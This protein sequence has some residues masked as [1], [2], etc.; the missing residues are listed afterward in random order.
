MKK[1]LVANRGEIAIRVFRACAEL[2]IATVGIYAA[3]DE[4]SVHRFKADEAYLIGEGKKPIEAYLDIEGIIQVAKEAGAD[5]IH[6]GYGF[7]SENLQ[8]AKRCQEEGLT[9]IGPKLEHLD[10]FGDKIKAKE[11]AVKAG[12]QSIPGSDGPVDSVDEV[13]DFAKDYGYPIMIKAALGGG[14][15][16][17]RV[18]FDD[19][20]ALEGYNRAKS[21]AK[22]AFGSDEVYVEKYIADPKHIEVQILG[23]MHGN[24]VHL[25]ERDCSVQRRHQ[26]V[27]EVAPCVS[28][29][30]EL[31]EKICGAAVQL[32]KHVGY[33]NAGTVEF[34]VS[35]DDFYFIEVNPRVQVEH[36]I[37]ELITDIDIV[38]SQ[39]LIAQ[40]KDLHKDIHIPHQENIYL[41]GAAIQCRI[42]TEDPLNNFMPDTG[43]ID[44]YRSPGG[45]GVRLDVGNAYAG[46][47]VTP[48]FDSL[49]VKVCT[50][51]AT[52]QAA[53]Q[54]MQ[55]CLKEFRIR[56]VKTNIPFMQNVIHNEVFQSGNA[57]TTFIDNTPSLFEF[58]STRDRGN[59]TM[60][61]IGEI[62]INGF[63][64]ID[65]KEKPFFE[66]PRV[67]NKIERSNQKI[68]TAKDILDKEGP[69]AVSKWVQQQQSVL[70]TDTTFRDAHQSLLATRVRT[71]DIEKIAAQTQLAIPQLFS[72]EMWGGATFDV[73]YR[74]LNE[75]PWERLRKIR[76]QMPNT[77]MQMLFRGSNA[78]GYSNYPDNVI[79]AFIKESAKQGID[80]FRIFDSLNWTAQMEPSIQAVLDTGKI[81]EAAICYTGDINDPL[82]SKYDIHYY[83][84]MA[85]D[86][87]S[88][89]AH[90]IAIKDMAGLLK[91]QAAYRLISELKDTVDVPIHLHTHDT[92]GNAIMTYEKAIQ[93]GVDI[94]DV[95]I[96]AMSAH[97]SQP[98]M[99]SLYYALL[100]DKR[101]PQMDIQKAQALNHYWEDVR[102]Y[103]QSFEN[104]MN[105][106][107][108]EVYLH[109]MPGGQYSNLQQQAKAVGLSDKWDEVKQ[110]YRKVNM[111]F[112]DI[113][114]V[115][116]SSKVVGDMALFM[117]QNQL[118]EEDLYEKGD[119]LSFPDSVVSFFEGQLGQPVGGFP[120]KLQKIILKGRP[121]ITVRPGQL[122]PAVDFEKVRNELAEKV[123][124]TP[125]DEQVLSYLM[126]PQVFLDYC[127]A[128]DQFGEVKLLDTPT[129]F[130]GMRLGEK[131]N[132]EIEKGK[133]LIIRLDEI[134]EADEEGNRILFFNLNGQRRE[135]V[136]N[137]KSIQSTIVHR[138]K[139]EP[140]DK[141][142]YGATMSGSVLQVLV[143]KGDHVKKGDVLMITEAMKMETAI[144]ARFDGVV[145]HLYVQP[146][147]IIQSGDLLIELK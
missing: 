118:T 43:K 21:E 10:I 47:V 50:H 137:D 145:D 98:S 133:V 104:G 56:G 35:G 86:L 52:F 5:A 8:F 128:Y 139:A 144:E 27:V 34:L 117:V 58:S 92:S 116:P 72:S 39:L 16:G 90:I 95:A 13:L 121:A 106:P 61:Y 65:K 19:A 26:K 74:F 1:V 122:A 17:M 49:L 62:T 54:K 89:G 9:F 75:D 60:K 100:G 103:Y 127:K 119:T 135:I 55:R 146:G 67:P 11:A 80:V 115:T 105:A 31:R 48:Y 91:P 3:E 114:K 81:A 38:T 129:F 37:T 70:L 120:E 12:I 83:K 82:R 142:Q 147:E 44:T 111:M 20:Q 18:A 123:G 134:G 33:V 99:S 7:L 77:L 32:M 84:Q 4:Y 24:V 112:G 143:K 97:T 107:Q 40:G 102:P 69:K 73:A 57:K 94:V 22:A 124:F 76:Q 87:E 141:N 64:G 42:T 113:V 15:R 63:P 51:G 93:A 131:I 132:V 46:A 110:M 130:Y 140:T 125:K 2:G 66:V 126:Y 29:S 30:T 108:T 109:E 53:V 85:K 36:T 14:G 68:V 96:S 79:Q 101:A 41:K 88:L 138:K 25:F 28:L 6:P 78:V 59:K 45:F 71:H 136:V 23:D